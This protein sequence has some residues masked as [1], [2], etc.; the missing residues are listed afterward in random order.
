[1]TISR[2]FQFRRDDLIAEP[3]TLDSDELDA[4]EFR[5]RFASRHDG[6]CH[7][8]GRVLDIPNKVLIA[9]T[10]IQLV[11]KVFGAERNI[12]IFG[13]MSELLD[14][15]QEI[16]IGGTRSGAIPSLV[17]EQLLKEFPNT[18]ELNRY[19]GA[20]VAS[21]IGDYIDTSKDAQQ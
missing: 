15:G 1:V 21:V 4:F 5:F 2:T 20:R 9:D 17:F 11:T 19:A 7:I 13:R 3:V 10:G 16:V 18:T 14:S 12:S 8:D 6:Y